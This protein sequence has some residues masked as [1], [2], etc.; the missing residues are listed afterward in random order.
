LWTGS[1]RTRS[2]KS[3]FSSRPWGEALIRRWYQEALARLTNLGHVRRAA[4]Q[5][6]LSCPLDWV[7]ACGKDRLA[8]WVTYHPTEVDRGRFVEKCH[9]LHRRNVRF[10]VGAVGLKEHLTEIEALRR[11]L[12]AGVYLWINA[13]KDRPDYYLENEVS[14]LEAIDP[15]FPLNNVRHPSF[16]RACRA[17]HTV[18]SVDGDGLIRRCHFIQT[19]LGNLYDRDFERSLYPR[20]CTNAAC[21]CHIGYVHLEHLRLYDVYGA[22]ILERIPEHE[23]GKG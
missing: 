16:G 14:R 2:T 20:P 17:G 10:S 1:R 19:P 23:I 6:N 15:L 8:L 12:P 4:I 5:T 21:G 13:Y 9:E 18:I 11:E 7:E 3:A 22:G